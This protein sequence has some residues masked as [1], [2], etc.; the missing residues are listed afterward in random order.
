MPESKQIVRVSPSTLFREVQGE[1]VLLQLDR[2]EYFGLDEVA[3]R[4]WQLVVEKGDLAEVEA[5]MLQE[6]EVDRAVLS[7]DLTRVVGELIAKGLLEIEH[8]PPASSLR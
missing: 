1:A 5:A 3:T 4:I 8:A 6:F 7:A 2:G